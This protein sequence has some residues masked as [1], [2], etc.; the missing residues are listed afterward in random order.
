MKSWQ[1]YFYY[2]EAV[3]SLGCSTLLMAIACIFVPGV[4]LDSLRYSGLSG[5]A[6]APVLLWAG[7]MMGTYALWSLFFK[8][9]EGKRGFKITELPWVSVICGMAANIYPVA[10]FLIEASRPSDVLISLAFLTPCIAATHWIWFLTGKPVQLNE[11]ATA[12]KKCR[13]H[14]PKALKISC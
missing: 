4:A 1:K 2:P 5:F 6:W 12:R 11:Y 13:L 3:L 14:W 10:W 9:E 8:I 7:G